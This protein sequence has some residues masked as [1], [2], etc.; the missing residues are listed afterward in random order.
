MVFV[1]EPED[2]V[3][4]EDCLCRIE[5]HEEMIG[6]PGEDPGMVRNLAYLDHGTPDTLVMMA[7]QGIYDSIARIELA[8]CHVIHSESRMRK[9]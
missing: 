8:T 7:H 3:F 2:A 6:Y 5:D 9:W 4:I 1:L